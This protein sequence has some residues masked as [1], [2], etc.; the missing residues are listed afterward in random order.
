VNEGEECQAGFQAASEF[1][2]K[3]TK[4]VVHRF[5]KIEGHPNDKRERT[6]GAPWVFVTVLIQGGATQRERTMVLRN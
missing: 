1:A 5:Q 6:T 4:A 3:A 2:G